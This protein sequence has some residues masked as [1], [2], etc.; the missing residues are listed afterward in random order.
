MIELTISANNRL[1][2]GEDLLTHLGVRPGGKLEFEMLPG[3]RISLCAAPAIGA[4]KP[5]ERPSFGDANKS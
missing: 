5:R 1:T 3:G 2:L 4:R